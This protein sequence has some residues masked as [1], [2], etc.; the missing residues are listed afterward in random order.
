MLYANMWQCRRKVDVYTPSILSVK[1]K[2]PSYIYNRD[3]LSETLNC[4]YPRQIALHMGFIHYDN[5]CNPLCTLTIPWSWRHYWP[6]LLEKFSRYMVLLL[7]SNSMMYRTSH[8]T[9]ASS[10]WLHLYKKIERRRH[11]QNRVR[12]K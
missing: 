10:S 6:S 4:R 2:I 1:P 12:R 5:L 3:C 11:C 8:H 9:N 7:I